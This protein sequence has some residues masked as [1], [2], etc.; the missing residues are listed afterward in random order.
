MRISYVFLFY[1]IL[2]LY[3][4]CSDEYNQKKNLKILIRT[5]VIVIVKYREWL[6]MY[7]NDFSKNI[8]EKIIILPIMI[9][10]NRLE[11]TLE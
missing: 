4:N 9:L 10:L 8:T 1:I 11:R 7:P 6:R 5:K 2:L 3:N